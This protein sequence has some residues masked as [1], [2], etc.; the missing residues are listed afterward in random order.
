[1]GN[2]LIYPRI[3]GNHKLISNVNSGGY[4]GELDSFLKE[5]FGESTLIVKDC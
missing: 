3:S 2:N 5:Q 4:R 1:M